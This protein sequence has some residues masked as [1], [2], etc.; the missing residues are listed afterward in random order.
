MIYKKFFR[1]ITIF[2]ILPFIFL[3]FYWIVL[4]NLYLKITLISCGEDISDYFRES[5]I[6]TFSICNVYTY[7]HTLV[8]LSSFYWGY[9]MNSTKRKHQIERCNSIQQNKTTDISILVNKLFQKNDTISVKI[10][11][12]NYEF[13]YLVLFPILLVNGFLYMIFFALFFNQFPV[14][15]HL[16]CSI[17]FCVFSSFLGYCGVFTYHFFNLNRYG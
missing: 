13:P 16:F 10:K 3:S 9:Y 5:I 6:K 12:H 2:L 15:V 4:L 7:S 17:I 1:L 14:Y 8:L 11:Y